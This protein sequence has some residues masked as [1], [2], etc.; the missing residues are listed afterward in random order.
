MNVGFDW[1]PSSS[2]H[3]RYWVA[4]ALRPLTPSRGCKQKQHPRSCLGLVGP[5]K[6]GSNQDPSSGSSSIYRRSSSDSVLFVE[7][8]K[9]RS[10]DSSISSSHWL[11]ILSWPISPVASCSR[12]VYLSMPVPIYRPSVLLPCC[13]KCPQSIIMP[14]APPPGIPRLFTASTS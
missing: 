4:L 14:S 10:I 7:W 3:Y 12:L 9:D 5:R 11:S 6:P 8:S 13:G 2:R 1:A